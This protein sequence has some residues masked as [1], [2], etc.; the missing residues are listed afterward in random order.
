MCAN[1][2][3]EWKSFTVGRIQE[4][5]KHSLLGT[6]FLSSILH[7]APRPAFFEQGW[8]RMFDESDH[9]LNASY[10][11]T[12]VNTEYHEQ[13]MRR[14]E[15]GAL[16]H[17]IMDAADCHVSKTE[18][19]FYMSCL[20]ERYAQVRQMRRPLHP[21]R[22]PQ[23]PGLHNRVHRWRRYAGPWPAGNHGYQS[24]DPRHDLCSDLCWCGVHSLFQANGH[25]WLFHAKRI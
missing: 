8:N 24:S 2:C 23:S 3:S 21:I 22:S 10:A 13:N 9:G 6:Q 19:R 1:N 16:V 4:L 7:C 14:D 25:L 11:V 15:Y 20:F 5:Q 17:T 12:T 18:L